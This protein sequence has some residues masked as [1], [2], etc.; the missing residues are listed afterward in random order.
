M[1]KCEGDAERMEQISNEML[2]SP[3]RFDPWDQDNI[4]MTAERNFEE[5]CTVLQ[6]NGIQQPKELTEFEFYSK[7]RY[8]EKKYKKHG[9][10][11]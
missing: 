11:K 6:E 10:H 2:G 4:V 5:M 1:A 8:Y 7:M 9:Q 3:R